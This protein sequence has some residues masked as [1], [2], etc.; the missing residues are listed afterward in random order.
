PQRARLIFLRNRHLS[1]CSPSTSSGSI[2]DKTML[3]VTSEVPKGNTAS[4]NTQSLSGRSDFK[5]AVAYTS[6][7]LKS[8]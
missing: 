6:F 7:D 4:L 8:H 1:R 2:V 5:D 3:A